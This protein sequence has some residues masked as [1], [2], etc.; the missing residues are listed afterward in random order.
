LRALDGETVT[1]V[2]VTHTH[3][4]HTPAC[5]V[6]AAA[7]GAK[8]HGFGPHGVRAGDATGEAGADYGFVPDVEL[9]D[10]DVIEGPGWSLAAV[11]TPGHTSNHL[12]YALAEEGTLFTG[13]HVM[14]WSTSVISPPDGDM[15]AYVRSL[16][17]LLERDDRIYRPT[18]G[19]AIADPKP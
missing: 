11:H 18:H 7:T 9:R 2:V 16:E 8:T 19:P 5:P 12:C 1:H 6:V 15:G 13:D 3:L 14:G 17:R 10:G 4:D